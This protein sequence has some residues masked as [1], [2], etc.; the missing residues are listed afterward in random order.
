MKH[1]TITW[2]ACLALLL[3][4]PACDSTDSD[5]NGSGNQPGT[6]SA[7]VTGAVSASLSGVAVST[8]SA[9][10]GGWGIVLA[11]G[12]A[13]SITILT[14]GRD[15]P[16]E[17]TFPIVVFIQGGGGTAVQCIA[18]IVAVPGVSSYTSTG[19]TLTIESS[20]ATRVTGSFSF[21][22]QRGTVGNPQNVEAEGTF[23]ATNTPV[24]GG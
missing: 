15:R 12:S 8:G 20:A 13:Q 24:T 23:N 21:A 3:S 9:I 5:D 10:T 17:G 11:P 7:T 16:P 6:F 4:L 2:L 19:G 18:S 14:P 22:A 1:A